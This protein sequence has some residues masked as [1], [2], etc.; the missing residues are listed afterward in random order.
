VKGEQYAI[1]WGRWKYIDASDQGRTE[2]YDLETDPGEQV[3]R[4]RDEQHHAARL[5]ERLA[6]WR[7][8]QTGE[9]PVR[10]ISPRDRE[11]LEALGYVE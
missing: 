5:A 6:A 2:L 4:S 8:R 3:D 11:A 1:R 7:Q 10:A 9:R